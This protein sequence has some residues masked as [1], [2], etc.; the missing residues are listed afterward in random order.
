MV[1]MTRSVERSSLI[2]STEPV[3]SLNGPSVILTVSPL[4]NLSFGLGCSAATSTRCR[5][6]STSSGVRG[7]G[8]GPE[9]KN[10]VTRGVDRTRC[11][12]SLLIS[13]S[14]RT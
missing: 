9:P 1:T 3:K 14:T 12:V 2:S 5:M 8:V 7:T 10:P 13:I 6:R 11:Q 4:S